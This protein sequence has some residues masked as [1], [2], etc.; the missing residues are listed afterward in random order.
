MKINGKWCPLCKTS[1]KDD[2]IYPVVKEV[3]T[4]EAI[5]PRG[6][7]VSGEVKGE[8]LIGILEGTS[9]QE[10]DK[11][12]EEESKKLFKYPAKTFH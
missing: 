8:Q 10:I 6:A 9:K 3:K 12:H 4:E 11:S 5:A 1:L 2:Q 7:I